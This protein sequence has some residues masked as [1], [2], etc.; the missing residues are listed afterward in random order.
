MKRAASF[1]FPTAQVKGETGRVD[2]LLASL[3]DRPVVEGKLNPPR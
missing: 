1:F 2:D 3:R